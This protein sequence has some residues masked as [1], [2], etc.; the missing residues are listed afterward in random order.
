MSSSFAKKLADS[1]ARVRERAFA[2]VSKWLAGRESLDEL[3]ARKLWRGLF[4]SYWHADGRAT[5]LDVADK[6]GALMHALNREVA[7][8]YAWACAW[9]MR[10][11]WSGIDKHRM[12]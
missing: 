4:Y 11:E 10:T 1:D 7:M 8:S 9:T 2:A 5:Q 3:D 12:D 6:M